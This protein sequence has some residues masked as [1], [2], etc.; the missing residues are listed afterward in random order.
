MEL[1]L[2]FYLN[3]LYLLNRSNLYIQTVEDIKSKGYI[4]CRNGYGYHSIVKE[5]R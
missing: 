3:T 5:V 2:S 4:V 1:I